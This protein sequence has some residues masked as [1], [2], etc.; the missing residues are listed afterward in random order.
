MQQRRIQWTSVDLFWRSACDPTALVE[1]RRTP[2][3]SGQ[4][5]IYVIHSSA[6]PPQRLTRHPSND[7]APSWSSDGKWV[8]FGSSRSG[9]YQLYKMPAAGGEALQLTRKGGYAALE[10]P[11]GK[12]L[13]C[14]KDFAGASIW[15]V[16]VDGGE[17]I[18]VLAS[19]SNY[20]NFAVVDEGIY[21]VPVDDDRAGS[22]I[23]FFTF[24]TG[25][26]SPVFTTAKPV[27]FGLTVSLDKRWILYSQRDLQDSDLM[28]VKNFR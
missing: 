4:Y 15:R 24:A 28:L 23:E 19:L 13:Y 17:E 1:G 12:T 5:E 6:G 7:V 2:G 27:G 11:D 10:S 18:Q 25:K 22:S 16:P 3:F 9:T 26:T 20:G 21:F 8:Y 14:A